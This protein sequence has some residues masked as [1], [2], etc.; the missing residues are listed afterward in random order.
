MQLK[1]IA[2]VL[3]GIYK[4]KIK[5]YQFRVHKL[6]PACVIKRKRYFKGKLSKP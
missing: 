2:F 3:K 4:G 1:K 5:G 6:V